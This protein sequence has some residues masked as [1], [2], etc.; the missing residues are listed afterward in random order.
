[1]RKKICVV[2]GSRADYGLLYPLIKKIK[3][4]SSLRLQLVACGSHLSKDFG[5]TY[6]EIE[7]DGFRIV[8]KVNSLLT[9]DSQESITKSTGR[10]IIIFADVYRRLKPD[11][12]ILLG[13]RYEIFA[14]CVA[15]FMARIPIAHI[16]GGE[17]SEGVIDDAL[18][19]SIT[20]MS[21]FH[22]TSNEKYR[23]R[24]IQLGESPDRV[25]NVGAL[26]V[27]NIR[28]TDL[29][30]KRQLEKEL[31]FRFSGCN[32]LVT[33]HPVTLE[34]NTARSQ[35]RQLFRALDVFPE[36]KIIFTK[37]NADAQGR[38]INRLIDGYVK[39]NRSRGIAF[40]SLGRLK[41]LSLLK[42]VNVVVGNSSSGIIEAPIFL[43]PSVNIGDRQRGRIKPD[44]VIDCGPKVKAIKAAIK[45]ALSKNFIASRKKA[46]NLY[47]N[48]HA[49]EKIVRILAKEINQIKDVKKPFYDVI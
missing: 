42:A 21:L 24:V 16:H 38:S 25:F 4:R 12:V 19:H 45:K 6:K 49:A 2:T 20:K 18:R 31:N 28:N 3:L 27:D 22:F 36:S 37:T 15:A 39:K 7:T 9:G 17:L 11:L 44:T 46:K 26:A 32:I 8:K 43:K 34:H 47:G 30:S 10:G 33:F 5:L 29:L 14:A 13:D 40:S 48:G 23:K 41:Y 35:L 1:M